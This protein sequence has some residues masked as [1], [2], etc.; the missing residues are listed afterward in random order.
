M[1]S[2]S[3]SELEDACDDEYN[4]STCLDYGCPFGQTL[5][6]CVCKGVLDEI[7]I[8]IVRISKAYYPFWCK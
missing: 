5:F 7:N 1:K 4:D 3:S 8:W 2:V 6:Q